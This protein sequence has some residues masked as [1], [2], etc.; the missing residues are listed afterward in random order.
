M[1]FSLASLFPVRKR[2]AVNQSG[3]HGDRPPDA[4]EKPGRRYRQRMGEETESILL[5]L[6]ILVF[7]LRLLPGIL[8]PES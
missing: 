1:S 3:N 8:I 2:E 7:R 6:E 5:F 4:E